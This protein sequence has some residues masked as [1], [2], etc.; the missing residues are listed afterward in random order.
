MRDAAERSRGITARPRAVHGHGRLSRIAAGALV[1]I[2][3]LLLGAATAAAQDVELPPAPP[4]APPPAAAPAP[5]APTAAPAPEAAAARAAPLRLAI[6]SYG[7]A[8]RD[9]QRELRRR[10]LR[11]TV[12]GAF[13]PATRRAVKRMQKRLRMRQTGVADARLLKRLGLRTRAVASGGPPAA[14]G[15]SPYL[16][17]FPVAGEHSFF[18]DFGAPRGQGPHQGNDIMAARGTPIVAV[19]DAVVHRLARAETGLGGI[20][21]WLERADGVQYYYAHMNTIAEGFDVGSAVAV[22]QVIGTVGNT[23]DAR[24]G[25]PHLHFEIRPGGGSPISPYQHLVAV[26]PA[27]QTGA[28][29]GR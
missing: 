29:G 10:G 12:D 18:D 15:S 26:D 9:L 27:A 13:G 14:P 24:H 8:V 23:G 19:D 3:I 11:I 7:Q 25:S 22:G 20:Y 6:G 17:V 16:D 21:V 4:A 2:T 5:P 1:L 28:N